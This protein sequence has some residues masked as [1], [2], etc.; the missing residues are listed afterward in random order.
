[1]LFV[2]SIPQTLLRPPISR[3]QNLLRSAGRLSGWHRQ[4][5]NPLENAAKQPLRQVALRQQHPI[6]AGVFNQT[7]PGFHQPLLQAR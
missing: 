6:V 1:M 2:Q 3:H 4:R 7:A 5:H